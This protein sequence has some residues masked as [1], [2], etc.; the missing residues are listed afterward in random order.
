MT[1]NKQVTIRQLSKELGVSI[2]TISSVLNNRHEERRISPDTVKRVKEAA[3]EIGYLPNISARM[4][5]SYS[6]SKY[7]ITIAVLTSFQAPLP[8]ISSVITTLQ[9]VGN[10]D[11]YKDINFN[12][13]V[14]MFEAGELK[15]LPGLLDGTRFNA[16]LIANTIPT[17]DEFLSENVISSPVVFIGRDIPHYSSVKTVAHMT[18]RQAAD[19]LYSSGSKDPVILYSKILTQTTIA[20]IEGFR[21]DAERLSGNK[22]IELV[23]EGFTEKHGYEAMKNFLDS[24][25]KIDGLYTITDSLAVGSYL[26]VKKKGLKIPEDITVIG[27]GDSSVSPYIDPPLST[28]TR[29]QHNL[30][31]EAV[32]LLFKQIKG[33][34]TMPTQVVV[35]VMP[36]LRESTRRG[37]ITNF[38]MGI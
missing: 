28:F 32:R 33:T 14:D 34:I 30:H 19:I 3:R 26:A 7:P 4:L 8:L 2:S 15:K 10:E 31:E 23:A 36:V 27:T 1:K 35:P 18:G 25:G 6:S 5:R 9:K 24:G 20:R 29:S 11:E 37:S 21:E 38:E 12:V 16:A 13:T 22:P 17:D